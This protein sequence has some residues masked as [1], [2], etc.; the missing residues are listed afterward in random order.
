M[1]SKS[2]DTSSK[3]YSKLKVFFVKATFDLQQLSNLSSP[4]VVPGSVRLWS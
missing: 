4:S 3:T 2:S 1:E